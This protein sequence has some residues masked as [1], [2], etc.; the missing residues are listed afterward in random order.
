[1]ITTSTLKRVNKFTLISSIAPP[2]RSTLEFDEAK[3]RIGKITGKPKITI[4]TPALL[5]LDERAAII[6]NAEDSPRHPNN[7]FTQNQRALGPGKPNKT[8]N[9]R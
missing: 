4:I 9:S 5:V 8:L 2:R 6:V 7:R 3:I 1:M